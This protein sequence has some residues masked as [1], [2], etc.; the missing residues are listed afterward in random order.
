MKIQLSDHFTYK[1]LIRFTLPSIGMMIFTSIYGVVDGFFVSNYVGET[2]FTAVNFIMPFLMILGAVGFMFGAGGSALVS[3]T[4]G[5]GDRDKANKLFSLFIYVPIVLGIIITVLG[6]VFLEPV[7][8]L[9]GA[10]GQMLEDCVRYGRIIALGLVFFMLQM[11]FQSFMITA[12]KPQLSFVFT[13]IAGFT[14]MVLDALFVAA[15][16]WGLE[17]AALATITSQF[18]GFICPLVYFFKKNSSLLR[19]GKAKMDF[20]AL[21][22]ACTN[23][24]S[25]LMSNISMSLVGMLYNTQLLNYAGEYGVAAYGV[26]M[27]VNFIFISAFIGY[28]IG[29]APVIGYHYGAKNSNELKGLLRKSTI[30]ILVSSV[31]MVVLAEL[32]ASP[33]SQLFVGYNEELCE[34]TKRAFLFYSF[35]FLFSGFAIFG[36][37][38]FTALNNGPISAIISFLRTLVFQV[39]AVITLPIIFNGVDGIWVS[40]IVAEA[41][42]VVVTVIFIFAKRKK[43]NY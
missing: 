38:F 25:E 8:S 21:L 3:K 31:A 13:L 33:M 7:A 22:K 32:L 16:N 29:C 5:E 19:L 6:I 27:Y 43:Y 1:K 28:S 10:E 34:L 17:G 26:L 9:L 42:A 23:G 12:E 18:V 39:V 35:S 40:I 14:N 15:F 11:E 20:G 30:I 24:S 2:A 41:M 37:S 36:S 4:L